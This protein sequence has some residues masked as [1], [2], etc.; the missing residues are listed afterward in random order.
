MC[1]TLPQF[2]DDDDFVSDILD[3]GDLDGDEVFVVDGD[4]VAEFVML[5]EAVVVT[6]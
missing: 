5:W 1:V 2:D 4:L 6:L 3:D